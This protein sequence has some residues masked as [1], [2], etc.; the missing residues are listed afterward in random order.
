MSIE[1]AAFSFVEQIADCNDA[2]RIA[3]QFRS[4]LEGMGYDRILVSDLK[5][6]MAQPQKLVTWPDMW[7]NR[8][9]EKGYFYRDPVVFDTLH[10]TDPFTWAE[11]LERHN[12][13]FAERFYQEAREFG[14][15][16]GYVIPIHGAR[17]YRGI[18]TVA[19]EHVA[20]DSRSR[21]AIHLMAIYCHDKLSRLRQQSEETGERKKLTPRERECLHWAAVGKTDDEIAS[22]LTI[23]STTAHWHIENAKR[24]F[25]VA[26]RVQAVLA[27]FRAGE[28]NI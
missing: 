28:L 23:S 17:R 7:R 16:H 11:S 24:K 26:T 14:M 3:R 6:P 13:P 5:D 22:I 20:L 1:T 8:Y 21:A 18:V 10:R 25:D 27:A 2:D 19:G 9:R 15:R 4:L 12:S